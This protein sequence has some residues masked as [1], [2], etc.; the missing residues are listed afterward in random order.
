MEETVK[1][2]VRWRPTRTI[3]GMEEKEEEIVVQK[4]TKN[5]S[6]VADNLDC[7]LYKLLHHL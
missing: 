7:I 4:L 2:A 1:I 3:D 6:K 5:V